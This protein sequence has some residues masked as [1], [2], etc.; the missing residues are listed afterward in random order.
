ML[1]SLHKNQARII[2][3]SFLYLNV[4]KNAWEATKLDKWIQCRKELYGK[5]IVFCGKEHHYI[6][7]RR[8]LCTGESFHENFYG[9]DISGS[10]QHHR[11]LGRRSLCD[12]SVVSIFF[13]LLMPS[14]IL[15]WW[16]GKEWH[17]SS[18]GTCCYNTRDVLVLVPDYLIISINENTENY[19]K[20]NA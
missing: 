20:Q 4:K 8:L 5:A 17:L 14:Y 16:S 1:K 9:H 10:R 19:D 6:L 13:L 3:S 11:W 12:W 15:M 7:L 18:H 2:R